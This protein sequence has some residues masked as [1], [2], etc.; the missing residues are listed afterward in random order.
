MSFYEMR[1]ESNKNLSVNTLRFGRPENTKGYYLA[2]PVPKPSKG[3]IVNN[4]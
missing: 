2:L 1:D 4:L 3:G